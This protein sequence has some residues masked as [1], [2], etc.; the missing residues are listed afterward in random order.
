MDYLAPIYLPNFEKSKMEQE[1]YQEIINSKPPQYLEVFPNPTKGY[2]IVH[3]TLESPVKGKIEITDVKGNVLKNITVNNL[4]DQITIKT[5]NWKPGI[6]LV[7]LYID[8]KSIEGCK[9]S[10]LE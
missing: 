7:N 5:E 10:I 6:Y 2:I 1:E 3:Y 4:E 8:G 9:V